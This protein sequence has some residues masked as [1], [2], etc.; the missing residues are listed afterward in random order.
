MSSKQ[1]NVKRLILCLAAAVANGRY[2][3]GD[4]IDAAF[5]VEVEELLDDIKTTLG[6]GY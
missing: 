1:D 4:D 5:L 3:K 6:Y 2:G